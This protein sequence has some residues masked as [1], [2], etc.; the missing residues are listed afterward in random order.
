MQ[1]PCCKAFA[2]MHASQGTGMQALNVSH[3]GRLCLVW[4]AWWTE[5][6][7]G[8]CQ[9]L[10]MGRLSRCA[11]P[12]MLSAVRTLSTWRA[13]QAFSEGKWFV[14]VPLFY[15]VFAFMFA[16]IRFTQGVVRRLV[17]SPHW[18]SSRQWLTEPIPARR[19]SGL[20]CCLVSVHSVCGLLRQMHARTELDARS[21]LA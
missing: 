3:A 9:R 13:G 19:P 21:A 6:S 16:I 12:T 4:S 1:V 18:C 15:L 7:Q 5:Q 17:Q 14:L 20:H 10:R 11:L 2:N 8:V